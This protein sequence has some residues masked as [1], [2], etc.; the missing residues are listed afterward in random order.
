MKKIRITVPRGSKGKKFPVFNSPESLYVWINDP[1]LQTMQ[2]LDPTLGTTITLRPGEVMEVEWMGCEFILED[3]NSMLRVDEVRLAKTIKLPATHAKL[4]NL[5]GVHS[6]W[7]TNEIFAFTSES[8]DDIK[9]L[10]LSNKAKHKFD[11]EKLF[12]SRG[13][14]E[15]T[16][17]EE[18]IDRVLH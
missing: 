10:K 8:Q 6:G 16:D 18:T 15:E 7:T 12:A 4:T 2:K 13:L 1:E 3:K 17:I 11:I 5:V 14:I 9:V